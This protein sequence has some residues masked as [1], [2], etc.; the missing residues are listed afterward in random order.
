MTTQTEIHAVTAK[1]TVIRKFEDASL[2][3]G[4]FDTQGVEFPGCK[5]ETVSTT[6]TVV[7]APLRR[8][9]SLKLVRAA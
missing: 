1:G 9:G 5:L 2:A 6:V 3:W 4:W 7:R 8:R